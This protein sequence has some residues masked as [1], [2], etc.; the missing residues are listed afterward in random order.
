MR[1]IYYVLSNNIY[2][3]GIQRILT[4]AYFSTTKTGKLALLQTDKIRKTFK[5]LSFISSTYKNK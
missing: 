3:K 1:H 2:T 4:A 5:A